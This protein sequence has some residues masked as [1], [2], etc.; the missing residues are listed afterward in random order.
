MIRRTRY[1]LLC[2]QRTQPTGRSPQTQ[3]AW[4]IA[5]L[6]AVCS[7]TVVLDLTRDLLRKPNFLQEKTYV[8]IALGGRHQNTSLNTADARSPEWNDTLTFEHPSSEH[9][10]LSL[11]IYS[12]HT[13]LP[14]TLIGSAGK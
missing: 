1:R 3:S 11:A 7:V 9:S 14:D 6:R 10:D 5:V 2:E 12:K 13:L 8:Y 4:Q